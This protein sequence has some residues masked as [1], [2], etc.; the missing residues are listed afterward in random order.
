M[1]VYIFPH[2]WVPPGSAFP[3]CDTECVGQLHIVPVCLFHSAGL[4]L[5]PLH[6]G[7]DFLRK[8]YTPF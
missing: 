3:K 6:T 8:V 5:R 4:F 1:S 7:E 2:H